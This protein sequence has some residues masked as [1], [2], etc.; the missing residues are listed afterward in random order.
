[1]KKIILLTASLMAFW[2]C[3]S[4][5]SENC[6]IEK[7]TELIKK[8][9]NDPSSFEFVELIKTDSMTIGEMSKN[10]NPEKI[11]EVE[12][13]RDG[14]IKIGSAESLE[15][16]ERMLNSA[17]KQLALI[18]ANKDNPDKIGLYKGDFVIRGNNA[19]GA[20]IKTNYFIVYLTDKDCSIVRL[21][22][23]G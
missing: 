6:V 20:K 19:F 14:A 5:G 4:K 7:A 22:P 18:E 8:D 15:N 13:L 11:K 23:E 10:I 3:S 12:S 1:M 17:T 2:S 21:Q 16:A 9:M